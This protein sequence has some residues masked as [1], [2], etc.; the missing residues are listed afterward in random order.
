[1][2][3]EPE[4]GSDEPLETPNVADEKEIRRH[5]DTIKSR[6]RAAAR[7]WRSVLADKT[8]RAEMYALLVNLRTYNLPFQVTD[9]G[10]PEPLA[11][12][13]LAGEHRAGNRI[14]RMLKEHDPA[15][16]LQME[17]ENDP[18]LAAAIKAKA[19]LR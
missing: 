2:S 14:L 1:M 18:T 19:R 6:Q 5:R 16:V 8:G 9:F 3:D 4:E 13:T 12:Y 7:F 10:Y 11:S 17:C 15:G